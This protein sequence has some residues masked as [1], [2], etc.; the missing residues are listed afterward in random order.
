MLANGSR[1]GLG[2]CPFS[3]C[4]D[5]CCEIKRLI[6]PWASFE[7]EHI[8]IIIIKSKSSAFEEGFK[9]LERINSIIEPKSPETLKPAE[10][11]TLL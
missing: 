11:A 8:I 6:P 4:L 1:F 7:A 2:F 5:D 9:D 10:L 3:Y